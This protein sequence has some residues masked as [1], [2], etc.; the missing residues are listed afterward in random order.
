MDAGAPSLR[1]GRRIRA[2]DGHRVCI[3]LGRRLT[4]SSWPLAHA[5]MPLVAFAALCYLSSFVLRARGGRRLFPLGQQ[6]GQC[7]CLASV[8]AGSWV[9]LDS[10]GFRCCAAAGALQRVS[11]HVST[12]RTQRGRRSAIA[13]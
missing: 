9:A 8:G 6:P 13:A 3:G 5:E 10:C 12:H 11:D 2:R 1:H 4:H 7:R